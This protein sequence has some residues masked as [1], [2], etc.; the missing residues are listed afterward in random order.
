MNDRPF[1]TPMSNDPT[2]PLPS[3]FFPSGL[4]A[5]GVD[6][7]PEP[8]SLPRTG[9]QTAV[10]PTGRGGIEAPS[11][12]ETLE[13]AGG[14]GPVAEAP[15]SQPAATIPL[16]EALRPK[17]LAITISGAVSLGS[18][19]A[20]V[21]Y[22]VLTAL[23]QHNAA[24]VDPAD[25]ILVDVLTGA[26]AGGMTAAIAGQMLAGND[27]RPWQ[28]F[29]NPFYNAWVKDVDITGLVRMRA[30]ENPLFSL[31]SSDCVQEIAERMIPSTWTPGAASHPVAAPELRLGLA[32]TNLDGF[33]CSA[34]T[35]NGARFIYTC[36]QDQLR[37]DLRAT[38]A[39]GW[40][41]IRS[42]ALACGAF[43]VAFRVREMI[44][45]TMFAPEA[46]ATLAKPFAYTDGGVFDNQPLGL[47]RDLVSEIDRPWD[48][49]RR[50][51]LFVSPWPKAS[52]IAPD[53]L[54]AA[55]ADFGRTLGALISAVFNQA[56]F[57]DWVQAEATNRDLAQ[58]NT[59]AEQ[60]ARLLLGEP[61][62]AASL[63]PAA[64]RLAGALT[65]GDAG[66]LARE[67]TR[68]QRVFAQLG[69]PP[70][71]YLPLLAAKSAAAAAAW[72][73]TLLVFE[74]AAGLEDKVEMTIYLVTA[75]DDE[76]ASAALSAFAGFFD[77][78][79]R[80]HDYEVGRAKARAW[81]ASLATVAPGTG[82]TLGPI[83]YAPAP[84]SE[85][86]PDPA[87]RD[88]PLAKTSVTGRKLLRSAILRRVDQL[89]AKH[90]RIP[91]LDWILRGLAWLVA[92]VVVSRQLG[93]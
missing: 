62:L 59:R 65:G 57:R 9:V 14:G 13:P 93:L 15:G 56:R 47:A 54:R 23:A 72:I 5:P 37:R 92:R 86:Q 70:V 7:G 60:L 38:D 88:L 87:L 29:D 73:D 71:D 10:V 46:P 24:V 50:F 64:A 76:L 4:P 20:G 45:T 17:R 85:P 82:P 53:P 27:G 3:G 22:E 89:V 80:H 81:L 83:R 58:L 91:V 77:Q 55:Q 63:A 69:T 48:N 26:S 36:Y 68:L 41:Q 21:L 16:V 39:A 6:V 79:Y 11:G 49:D 12:G 42:A 84:G 40:D 66:L 43:P 33:D 18:Y 44:R 25:R 51:Y 2:R 34:A 35:T 75:Q 28:V 78:R 52:S 8:S 67:R 61:E 1:P 32:L 74:Y 90:V 19:E 31:L 30:G